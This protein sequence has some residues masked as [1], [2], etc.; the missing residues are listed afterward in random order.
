MSLEDC[1][2]LIVGS[3]PKYDMMPVVSLT[4]SYYTKSFGETVVFHYNSLE[5]NDTLDKLLPCLTNFPRQGCFA[6][7]LLIQA[8]TNADF[9]TIL[10]QIVLS[11]LSHAEIEILKRCGLPRYN[12]E[13][14]TVLINN[15][16]TAKDML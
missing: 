9:E 15:I 5:I 1:G 6:F 14:M 11:D 16:M 12:Y 4:V 13:Q 7:S 2:I 3:R 10:K 8:Q